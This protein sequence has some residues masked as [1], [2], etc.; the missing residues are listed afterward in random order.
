LKPKNIL[1][2]NT[3]YL[4]DLIVCTPVLRALRKS[5]PGSSITILVRQEYKTVLAGNPNIDEILSFDFA[6]KKMKGL[7]R[8]KAEW[9]F[10]K[11]LRSKKFDAVISLQSGDRYTEWTYLSGAKVRVAP[12]NQSLSFL[13][14]KKVDV[15]EDTISYLDYYLKIAEA[16]HAVS[17]AKKTDFYLDEK[18]KGWFSDFNSK[19]KITNDDVLVGIHAGAS[20]PSKIWPLGKFIQLIERLSKISKV[21]IIMFAGPAESK[22]FAGLKTSL[23]FITADTSE[24]IQQLAWLLNSCKLFIANDSGARHIAAALNIPAITLFPEDK[25][26]CWKFYEELNNQYFIIGKRKTDNPQ[27]M[28]LDC[29]EVDVVFQKAKEILE[30]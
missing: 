6:I 12:R 7:A 28:F 14:S 17:D 11:V 24:D 23:N 1:I 13:I 26:S 20:E 2:I 9:N 29:I 22:L 19:N 25:L 3:K 4:G 18:F 10:V 8:L 15:Y 16:F 5:F 30:K 27:N 21:K